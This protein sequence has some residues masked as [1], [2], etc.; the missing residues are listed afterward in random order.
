MRLCLCMVYG[1]TIHDEYVVTPKQVIHRKKVQVQY[2]GTSDDIQIDGAFYHYLIKELFLSHYYRIHF[3]YHWFNNHNKCLSLMLMH[4]S[5]D[6]IDYKWNERIYE[7]VR[8]RSE[9][10]HTFSWLSTLGGGFSALG[11]YFTK[12]AE[13]AGKI[14]IHQLQIGLRLGDPNITARCRL[15]FSLSL[16]QKKKFRLAKYIIQREFCDAKQSTVID[17]RLLNMCKGIW[18]KLQYEYHIYKKSRKRS[19][20]C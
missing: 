19:K 14:S 6:M 1:D 11:D 18:A 15:Y 8:E 9:L 4:T 5:Y 16:I 12:C 2:D 13:I 20:L 17:Q 10:D 7:M 3:L